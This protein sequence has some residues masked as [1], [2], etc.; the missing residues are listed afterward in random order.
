MPGSPIRPSTP[1]G[2]SGAE[3]PPPPMASN[4]LR[5]FSLGFGLGASGLTLTRFTRLGNVPS[6]EGS[7]RRTRSASGGWVAKNCA[8]RL[9]NALP[10]NMWLISSAWPSSI[11]DVSGRPPIF[12][13]APPMPSGSRVYCTAEASARYSR[14]RETPALISLPKNS[15]IDPTTSNPRATTRITTS[16]P[17]PPLLSRELRPENLRLC[18][19]YHP[20]MAST[21]MPCSTPISRRLSRMSPLRI[22]LNSWAM[23]PCSSSRSRKSR[24]P[25]ETPI[26]ASP[27]PWPAAKALMH[28]SFSMT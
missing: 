12:F 1:V 11:F 9:P 18:S 27:G 6:N 3:A 4:G 20:T 8:V 16:P 26:T 21:R 22:W 24:Q 5:G 13:N 2:S 25:C 14:C 7:I 17:P 28:G 23:T 15:P 19:T 10:K